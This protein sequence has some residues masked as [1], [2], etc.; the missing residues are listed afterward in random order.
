MQENGPEHQRRCECAAKNRDLLIFWRRANKEAGFQILRGCAAVGRRDANDAADGKR[1]DIVRP[2]HPA[3]HQKNQ[4]GEQQSRHRHSGNRIRGRTDLSGKSRGNGHEQKAKN[5]NQERAE[6][7]HM[8]RGN[9][10]DGRNERENP[11]THELHREVLICSVQCAPSALLISSKIAQTGL[12]S[13]PDRGQRMDHAENPAR[14]NSSG[15]NIKNV[16]IANLIWIHLADRHRSR[17]K[18]SSQR[19]A[20]E[21]Y[22][23]NQNQIC[24][25]AT[26]AHD[27]RDARSDDVTDAEQLRS[28]FRRDRSAFEVCAEYVFR[29]FLPT[30]ERNHHRFINQSDS[31]AGEDSPGADRSGQPSS[32]RRFRPCFCFFRCGRTRFFRG[33]GFEHGGASCAFWI[34]QNAVFLDDERAPQRDHH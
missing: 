11:N 21:L 2:A 9:C 32:A 23:G 6:Q 27:G 33:P 5:Y 18:D 15:A 10:P 17:L 3:H 25:H 16:S 28:D 24:Q 7:I 29:R 12:Q 1:S 19:A 22:R 30:F 4:T 26:G 31:E 14:R 13:M 34:F 8:Q 20:E